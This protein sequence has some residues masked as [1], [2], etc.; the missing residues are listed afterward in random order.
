MEQNTAG[1]HFRLRAR[2]FIVA[3]SSQGARFGDLYTQ[4][5]LAI[6]GTHTHAG[7]GGYLQYVVYSVTSLGFIKQS[8]DAIVTAIEQSIVQAHNNL[9][10]GSVF[11]NTGDVEN[12]GI[13]RSPSAYLFNPPEERA[14]YPTDV[15]TIM[16]LVKFLDSKSQTSLGAFTWFATHGTSMSRDN[17]L[18]SGDNKGAAARFF[19][20]WFNLISNKSLSTSNTKSSDIKTL[21]EKAQTIKA[22]GGQPCGKTASQGF[23]VR[24]NDGLRFVGA[25][26]QSN[27][28]DV[29]PN[30]L[31]AFCTDTGNSCDFNHSSCNGNDQL[32]VGRG[33]GYPDEILSTKIIGERQYQKAVELFNSASDQLSGKIDYRHT[34]L[35]FTNIEVELDGNT[36]VKTCPAALGP[37]FAAGTTDGPGVFG[38][39]QGDTE[40]N[41]MWKKLRDLLKEPSQYQVDCQQPKAVLLSTGEMF[42]PYAWAPAILPIQIL[43]LGKL[44]IL[45]V[46]G[47]TFEEYKQQRYEAASTIYGPYTLSAYIQEFKKLAKAMATGQ[48]LTGPFLLPPDLSSVQ[49]SLLLDPQGDLPPPGKKLG[50][51]NQ[52][53]AQPKGGSFKKGDK[54][55]ANFYSANPRYDLLTEGTFAGV[56]MLQGE[57]WIPAYDDDDFSLFFKYK[58]DNTTFYGLATIEWEIPEEAASGVYRFR[59]FGSSKKTKDSPNE[60]FTGASS[61]FT[62]S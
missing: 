44:V 52:D 17:K 55:S 35:N 3:E 31:G 15:D 20:D 5:N 59:H 42:K 36:I 43:R 16:T 8:F 41:E 60:Y 18:V 29:T 56:E 11:L 1:I 9:K 19:E 30:V 54:P 27:V 45:S 47:A 37:G 34:Y 14:K 57:R 21:I 26:C 62:V 13:N 49:L 22:T 25:F 2:A 23:K 48:K 32:C 46:P 4:E 58:V 39:Q 53:V 24:K 38:F 7:P 12:A 40:I 28:G 50:D 6:S 51:I 33:P 10:P 61:A